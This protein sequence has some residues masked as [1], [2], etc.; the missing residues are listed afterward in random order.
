MTRTAGPAEPGPG[1]GAAP[2]RKTAPAEPA[3]PAELTK[4]ADLL[5]AAHAVDT[6]PQVG[7]NAARRAEALALQLQR[8]TD[9]AHAA[10][11]ACTHLLRLGRLQPLLDD[12]RR[13]LPLLVGEQHAA[14]RCELLRCVAMAASD[15]GAFDIGLD[16]AHELVQTAQRTGDTDAAFIAVYAQAVCLERMG[17]SWQAV[18]LLTQALQ[19]SPGERSSR[20]WLVAANAVCAINVGMAHRLRGTGAAA[21][22][23][24]A[25][26]NGRQYGLQAMQLLQS[27]ADVA[28]E[29]AAT[30]NLGEVLLLQGEPAAALPLLQRAQRLAQTHGLQAHHWRVQTTLADWRL[31][32]GDAAGALQAA[33]QLLADM[34]QTAPPQTAIRAHDSAYRAS[35]AQGLHERALQHLEAA[36]QRERERATAQLRAQS[37]LFVTRTES[38]R[39]RELAAQAHADAL[40]HR[41]QA[42]ELAVA[43]ERDPLTGLGNR[44]HLQ[45]RCSELLPQMAAAG[46]ALALAL[47]DVDHFKRINDRHGHAVGDRVLVALA[48]ILLDNTRAGDVIVR[49]GGEEFVVVLPGL[50]GEP[51]AE[52]FERLRQRVQ[53]HPWA[54]LCGAQGDI[55]VSIGLTW[56]PPLDLLLLLQ[57]ADEALYSAKHQGRNR[58]AL[59]GG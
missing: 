22:L 44:R 2:T 51:A 36:E 8:P 45:R 3:E 54:D 5:A 52:I 30:G 26:H 40:R 23:Q 27:V 18:R 4:L 43:A 17:D 56:A 42:A 14:A 7:L 59:R 11:A 50:A 13:V 58:L 1:P 10:A 25:L 55:T 35:R 37:L 31:A 21:E 49:H 28:Y 46:S 29:V 47:L 9:H 6:D 39:A 12:A 48:Q 53:Q 20:A 24:Q 19:S 38:Q 41:E 33:E 57:R 32:T 34:G 15:S 16:A